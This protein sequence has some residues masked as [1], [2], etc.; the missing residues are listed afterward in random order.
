VLLVEPVA[1]DVATALELAPVLAT[2][3]ALP[4][5]VAL[6]VFPEFP[7]PPLVEPPLPAPALPRSAAWEE[8]EDPLAG[9]VG[10]VS[11]EVPLVATGP[12]PAF[13]LAPPVLPLLELPDVAPLLPEAPVVAPGVARSEEPPPA[14]PLALPVPL[15]LPPEDDALVGWRPAF[16][17]PPVV[18]VFIVALVVDPP[19]AAPLTSGTCTPMVVFSAL[20]PL[21]ARPSPPMAMPLALRPRTLMVELTA[22]PPGP[23]RAAP[24]A[25]P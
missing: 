8:F 11:P 22:L 20:P 2:L 18:L 1:P 4:I 7:E 10:P 6:P 23:A 21:P 19:I 9:P 12:V 16:V 13:E 24:E 5:A 17:F 15:V 25:L 14:P 3:V